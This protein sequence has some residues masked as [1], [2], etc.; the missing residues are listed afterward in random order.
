MRRPATT[1]GV[2]VATLA[3]LVGLLGALTLIVGYSPTP[4]VRAAQVLT[5]LGLGAVVIGG[6]IM[7]VLVQLAGWHAPEDEFELVVRRA[8]RLAAGEQW[9]SEEDEY[10]WDDDPFELGP[11]AEDEDFHA[12]LHAAVDDLPL[13]YHRVLEHVAIVVGERGARVRVGRGRRAVYSVFEA[14]AGTD[15]YFHE[16]VVIFRDALVRDFGHDPDLLREQIARAIQG[17]LTR[18]MDWDSRSTG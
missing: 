4:V 18:H 15:D 10:G 11:L 3:V 6:V 7:L 1:R 2:I 14:D 5:V 12:L 8:E 13:E 16:R 17:E 9:G